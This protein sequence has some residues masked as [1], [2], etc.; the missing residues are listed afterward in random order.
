MKRFYFGNE[1]GDD[2]EEGEEFDDPR[3]MM[4]DPTEFIT[5]AGLESPYKHLLDCAIRICEKSLFWRLFGAGR[6]ISMIR[7]VFSDLQKLTEGTDDAQI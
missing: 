3:F 1:E 4:P 2:D 6:K 5:M 7:Q